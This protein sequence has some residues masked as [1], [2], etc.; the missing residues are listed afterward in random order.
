MEKLSLAQT[1][2]QQFRAAYNV[3]QPHSKKII[4]KFKTGEQLSKEQEIW[5]N[6]WVRNIIE[7]A[8]QLFQQASEPQPPS[9]KELADDQIQ[10]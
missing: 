9:R 4:D 1:Y 10:S 2:E 3:L 7:K 6:E 8:E 5:G